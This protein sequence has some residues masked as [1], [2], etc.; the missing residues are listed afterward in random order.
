MPAIDDHVTKSCV[1]RSWQT[2]Q[3]GQR[4]PLD[5]IVESFVGVPTETAEV[6]RQTAP[7]GRFL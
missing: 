1:K 3:L 4:V 7:G 2:R 5:Q 6:I